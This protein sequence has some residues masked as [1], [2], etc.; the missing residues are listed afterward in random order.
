MTS[1]HQRFLMAFGVNL[2]FPIGVG[3]LGCA[4]WSLFRNSWRS[5]H[6]SPMGDDNIQA[7]SKS[8]KEIR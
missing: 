5:P 2:F 3:L 1:R 7:S 8:H 6:P 4:A